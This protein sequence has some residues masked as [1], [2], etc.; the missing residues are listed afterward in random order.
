MGKL[1][2]T[3]WDTIHWEYDKIILFATE[4]KF[5]STILKGIARGPSNRAKVYKPFQIKTI[6]WHVVARM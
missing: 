2:K 3:Q 4:K 1:G 6:Q 5:F